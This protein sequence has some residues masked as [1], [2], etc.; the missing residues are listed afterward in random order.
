[1]T[2]DIAVALI[3]RQDEY[4]IWLVLQLLDWLLRRVRDQRRQQYWQEIYASLDC[5]IYMI[6]QAIRLT[7]IPLPVYHVIA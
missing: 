7:R 2:S 3:I 5:C 1:M 6:F 4:N